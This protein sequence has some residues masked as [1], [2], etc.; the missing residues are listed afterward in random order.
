MEVIADLDRAMTR[1]HG[2]RAKLVHLVKYRWIIDRDYHELKQ[3]LGLGH[4]EGS[5]WRGLHHHHS[6]HDARPPTAWTDSSL[7]LLRIALRLI[8]GIDIRFDHAGGRP[9]VVR[10][11]FPGTLQQFHSPE[12]LQDDAAP[13]FR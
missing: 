1:K 3:E 13:I 12:F 5:G 6:A 7:P 2:S 4:Y 11:G 8:L 10:R 9:R